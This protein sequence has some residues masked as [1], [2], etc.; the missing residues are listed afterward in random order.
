MF[1]RALM[2][3]SCGFTGGGGTS[4]GAGAIYLKDAKSNFETKLKSRLK[5]GVEAVEPEAGDLALVSYDTGL[6]KMAAY[7]S[8]DPGSGGS[9]PMIIW[10]ANGFDNS[11]S[12][13]AWKRQPEENDQSASVYREKGILMMYPSLRGGNENPGYIESFYG[14]VLDVFSALEYAKSLDYVDETRIYLGGHGTGGTL[15]LLASEYGEGFRAIF[16]LGPLS[17]VSGY[18]QENLNFDINDKNEVAIRSPILFI[19][20]IEAPTFVFESILNGNNA[21]IEAMR[22][23]NTN[24]NLN[25]YSIASKGHYSIIAPVNRLIAEKILNDYKKGVNIFFTD[26]EVK[27]LSN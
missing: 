15:A 25:L 9:W 2:I 18:G 17:D 13:I 12:D 21:S 26:D 11:I 1:I 24:E 23:L 3:S 22:S 10:L 19:N 5:A 8:P 14:E 20:T 27:K 6:G 4:Q 7:V 16:S